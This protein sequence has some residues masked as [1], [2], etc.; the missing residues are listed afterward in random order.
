VAA[1]TAPSYFFSPPSR[2][3]SR[4]RFRSCFIIGIGSLG[5][6]AFPP[7]H[8]FSAFSRPWTFTHPHRPSLS[9]PSF[10][11]H[12]LYR[13]AITTYPTSMHTSESFPLSLLPLT[14]PRLRH[15]TEFAAC[16]FSSLGCP[17]SPSDYTSQWTSLCAPRG[18]MTPSRS[19]PPLLSLTLLCLYF[20]RMTDEQRGRCWCGAGG[21]G[22]R[23]GNSGLP[24]LLSFL[25]AR[26]PQRKKEERRGRFNYAPQ[27]PTARANIAPM[28]SKVKCNINEGRDVLDDCETVPS[29]LSLFVISP[30]LFLFKQQK[31]KKYRR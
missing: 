23:G 31:R 12:P 30:P 13:Q 28:P 20:H 1:L 6:C 24:M 19:F 22:M 4:T 16:P 5:V 26:R 3:T 10:P 18:A 15:L 27:M 11:V 17:T 9:P 7:S 29:C 25:M 2:W 21:G 8:F 14:P